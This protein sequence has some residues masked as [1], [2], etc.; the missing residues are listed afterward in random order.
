MG[1]TEIAMNYARTYQDDFNVVLW[2]DGTDK[3]S[4]ESSFNHLYEIMPRFDDHLLE[5][6]RPPG[7]N[8]NKSQASLLNLIAYERETPSALFKK[9]LRNTYCPWLLV[10]DNVDNPEMIVV[11][12][13]L[14]STFR[15]GSI[16]IT[17]RCY[18]CERLGA[19]L[20][21][22]EMECSE[23]TELF[24][25]RS[26]LKLIDK[27]DSLVQTLLKRLGFLA[28][29]IDQAAAYIRY[30]QSTIEEYLELFE[31]EER[32]LLEKSVEG[33]YRMSKLSSLNEKSI[34]ILKTFELFFRYISQTHPEAGLLLNLFAFLNHEDIAEALFRNISNP[35]QPWERYSVS[36][37]IAAFNAEG[38][39]IAESLVRYLTSETR[40][41]DAT[42]ALLSLSLVKRKSEKKSLSIHPVSY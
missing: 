14:F 28:L 10:V 26:S 22:N 38:F 19:V 3:S 5:P 20:E 37:S 8:Y 25:S 16:I 7:H 15:V 11:L 41:R 18:Q 17:S 6:M 27:T 1:K 29:A 23:A 40:F 39:G 2:A 12:E 21:V 30:N 35:S 13:D 32:Y 31:K 24:F 9:W 34:T 33:R 36:G 42:S 4:L